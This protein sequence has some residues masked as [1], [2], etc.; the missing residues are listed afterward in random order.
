MFETMEDS[1]RH[2]DQANKIYLTA[3]SQ[4]VALANQPDINPDEQVKIFNAYNIADYYYGAL[5]AMINN[6]TNNISNAAHVRLQYMDSIVGVAIPGL[7]MIYFSAAMGKHKVHPFVN[8]INPETKEN[9]IY[10]KVGNLPDGTYV[11]TGLEIYTINNGL[12]VLVSSMENVY[13]TQIHNYQWL[14]DNGF[15]QQPTEAVG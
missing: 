11:Y 8:K 3:L 9:N 7:N 12:P 15:Y 1:V 6:L 14:I 4:Y 2:V 13:D 10:F 5:N